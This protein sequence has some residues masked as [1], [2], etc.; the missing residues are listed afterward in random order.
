MKYISY[1]GILL[2]VLLGCVHTQR[3]WTS[4]Q[5]VNVTAQCLVAASP[6]LPNKVKFCACVRDG[7]EKTFTS[8][9]LSN[10]VDVTEEEQKVISSITGTCAEE[11]KALLQHSQGL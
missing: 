8:E 1:V 6:A 10:G 2:T 9:W 11:Q 3:S 5:R 4:D 7:M